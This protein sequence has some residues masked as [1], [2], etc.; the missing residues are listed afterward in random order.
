MTDNSKSSD[1][2]CASNKKS[3]PERKL[4]EEKRETLKKTS[5]KNSRDESSRKSSR[6]ES[7]RKKLPHGSRKN[8]FESQKS[9][10]SHEII[11]VTKI[12]KQSGGG[13]IRQVPEKIFPNDTIPVKEV[14]DLIPIKII[15]HTEND[16][17]IFPNQ[18]IIDAP[19][20]PKEPQ[21]LDL[22]LP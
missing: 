2:S 6:D 17:N 10:E 20:E 7:H 1:E 3:E 8:S 15:G 22:N 11:E 14:H 13:D 21:M 19:A 12:V 18:L 9:L 4:S 16:G 5:R